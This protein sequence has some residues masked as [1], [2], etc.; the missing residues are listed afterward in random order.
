MGVKTANRIVDESKELCKEIQAVA[1]DSFFENKQDKPTFIKADVEGSESDLIRGAEQI[2]RGNKPMIAICVYH[3]IED[4]F[5]IP[6]RLKQLNPEY[7]MAVR[8]HMLNYHETV[9][10]C[11]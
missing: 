1:L 7:R 10:Y 8:H 3:Q 6:I 5:E 4:L 11:Y 9:L 2:I